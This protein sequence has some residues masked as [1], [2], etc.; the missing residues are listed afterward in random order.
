M[1]QKTIFVGNAPS[2]GTGTPIR[3]AFIYI[4]DNF[5]ELYNDIGIFAGSANVDYGTLDP[6]TDPVTFTID[7]GSIL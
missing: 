2:D 7:Y 4:N 5:T 6:I 1:T 3:T